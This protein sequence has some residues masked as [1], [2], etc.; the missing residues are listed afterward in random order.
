MCGNSLDGL[1]FIIISDR[2]ADCLRYFGIY[3]PEYLP[4]SSELEASS[5][6]SLWFFRI[7][8]AARLLAQR[9]HLAARTTRQ[10]GGHRRWHV[11]VAAAALVLMARPRNDRTLLTPLPHFY[12]P[13]SLIP[14]LTLLPFPPLTLLPFLPEVQRIDYQCSTFTGMIP[15]F[16]VLLILFEWYWYVVCESGIRTSLILAQGNRWKCT[17]KAKHDWRSY[18]FRSQRS[19]VFTSAHSPQAPSR[20][21]QPT[22]QLAAAS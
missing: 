1:Y 13:F 7:L 4:S 18:V 20:A 10:H 19:A 16:G 6:R 2:Y 9:L 22:S 3:K 12:S 8:V 14:P 21:T 15:V 11:L 17:A 5:S